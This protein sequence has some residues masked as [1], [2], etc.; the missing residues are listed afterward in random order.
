M[1]FLSWT[2]IGAL[3][4][5]K[6]ISP[7][8][9][10]PGDNLFESI[11]GQGEGSIRYASLPGLEDDPELPPSEDAVSLF[12]SSDDLGSSIPFSQDGDSAVFLNNDPASAPLFI[13]DASLLTASDDDSV[14]AFNDLPLPSWSGE[15]ETPTSSDLFE[16][17]EFD[18]EFVSDNSCIPD[19]EQDVSK[20]K[21]GNVC[22]VTEGGQKAFPPYYANPARFNWLPENNPKKRPKNQ[23]KNTASD[24]IHCASGPGGYRMYLIC[25]S[26]NEADRTYTGIRGVTLVNLRPDRNCMLLFLVSH[27]VQKRL[28]AEYTVELCED[29]RKLWCCQGFYPRMND[30]PWATLCEEVTLTPLPL[31]GD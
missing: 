24:F 17:S 19:E 21:R 30:T 15:S 4:G 12:S 22:T 13:E 11:D 26:G 9:S 8:Q 5:A 25:D 16:T 20:S 7:A 6:Y 29:P 23:Q 2:L 31:I 10:F 27:I 14:L 1:H 3:F 28:I 18:P